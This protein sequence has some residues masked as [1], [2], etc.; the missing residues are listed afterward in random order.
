[1]IIY[2]NGVHFLRERCTKVVQRLWGQSSTSAGVRK[3]RSTRWGTS[4]MSSDAQ[5]LNAKVER[6]RRI[7]KMGT[8]AASAIVATVER[9]ERNPRERE[10]GR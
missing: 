7:L 9:I 5:D 6:T 2:E 4:R 1:M 3:G 8:M 10:T